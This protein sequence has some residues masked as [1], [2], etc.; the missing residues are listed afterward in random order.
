[1]LARATRSRSV[2]GTVALGPN[3]EALAQRSAAD[4]STEEEAV[5][6]A[7]GNLGL[8]YLR[9]GSERLTLEQIADAHPSLLSDLTAHPGIGFVM[10]RSQARGALVIGSAGNRRL[11]DDA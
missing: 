8:V 11:A 7:S 5:V 6:M 3:R 4:S 9:L 2:D 1:M 10:V